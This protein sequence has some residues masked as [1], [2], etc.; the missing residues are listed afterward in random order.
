MERTDQTTKICGRVYEVYVAHDG[1]LHT[2]RDHGIVK[3]LS[4]YQ[5]KNMK[6]VEVV[7]DPDEMEY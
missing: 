4:P 3:R 6:P 2:I 7:A 1:T 5:I